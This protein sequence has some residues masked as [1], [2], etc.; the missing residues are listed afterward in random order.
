MY[1]GIV[2]ASVVLISG[3]FSY[4]Q[5]AKS[6]RI[7]DSF[8][9]LVPQTAQV[10]RNAEITSVDVTDLVVGDIVDVQ[11]GDRVPAD[12]RITENQ[13]LKV[14]NSSLTGES[15]PLP[16]S[17]ECTHP[18]PM[19]TKN[20]AFFSTSVIEGTGR[21]IVIATGDR[22][23]MG[24]VAG[25]ASRL[26]N[27][28]TPISREMDHFVSV[29]SGVAIFFGMLFFIISVAMGYSWLDSAVFLI[30]IIV[31][32]VPE[33][34]LAT[35][36]VCLALTAKRMAMKNCLVKHLEAVETLGMYI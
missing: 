25:L 13:G 19:E 5:E 10:L 2:L 17:V 35:V 12:I 18:N 30:G 27:N 4:Y 6:D 8:K 33:G 7:M 23:L 20:L 28:E 24:R 22:T 1:L 3:L 14:D 26:E 9:K 32:N 15:E 34:L 11:F 29:I 31:A 36:T 21:G 16:R